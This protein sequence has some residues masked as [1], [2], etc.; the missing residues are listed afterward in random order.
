MVI[1]AVVAL[2]ACGDDDSDSAGSATTEAPATTAGA[3][4]ACPQDGCEIK[5]NDA[6]KDGS[7]LKLTL[8]A[9][10][11]PDLS[12][13]HIHVYWDTYTAEQVSDDAASR[14]VEQGSWHPTAEYPTYVTKSEASV[15]RR[16][17]S[18]EICVTAGD[19][20]HN[21]IDAERFE[22]RDVSALL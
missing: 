3:Q 7:E 20:N 17:G 18:T 9:N 1:A 8:E 19:R 22:C 4:N 10:F 15:A 6:A 2:S 16:S 21:V 11:Q 14:G 5:I 12:R 13:N